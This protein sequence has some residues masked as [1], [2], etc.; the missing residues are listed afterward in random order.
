MSDHSTTTPS[1]ILTD[2]GARDCS[3]GFWKGKSKYPCYTCKGTG[4]VESKLTDPTLKAQVNE[5]KSVIDNLPARSKSFAESL[6]KQAERKGSLSPKQMPYL[7]SMTADGLKVKSTPK[8]VPKPKPVNEVTTTVGW[9]GVTTMMTATHEN[10]QTCRLRIHTDAGQVVFKSKVERKYLGYDKVSGK[11]NYEN[12]PQPLIYVELNKTL[13]GT[14]N[15]T[16]SVATFN[17]LKGR[18]PTQFKRVEGDIDLFRQ[19][20][21]GVMTAHGKKSGNCCFC[22]RDLTDHR[23]T[24][25]GYGPICAKRYTLPWNSTDAMVIESEIAEKTQ[26]AIVMF[27][28][29]GVWEVNDSESGDTLAT[30]TNHADANRFADE[31]SNIEKVA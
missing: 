9:E 7:L 14:I 30:F 11:H 3:G 22:G 4:K 29:E 20:P 28:E 17:T 23:S 1:L 27:V 13:V 10:L 5:L 2:C 6:I 16:E 8:P 31:Y 25:H 26:E 18:T 24:A 12:T 15:R 21:I 19:D